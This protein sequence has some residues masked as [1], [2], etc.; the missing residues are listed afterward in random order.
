MKKRNLLIVIALV[1]SADFMLGYLCVHLHTPSKTIFSP[2]EECHSKEELSFH[3]ID[4]VLVQ[5]LAYMKNAGGF[6]DFAIIEI[7]YGAAVNDGIIADSFGTKLLYK[8][9]KKK[10]EVRSA[11][12]DRQFGTDDDIIGT[13]SE[14][15]SGRSIYGKSQTFGC[16]S[17]F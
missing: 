9:S 11:G 16:G 3:I 2:E 17:E 7:P 15:M 10:L 13:V 4:S 12:A 1:L 6:P 5:A 14:S 8:V